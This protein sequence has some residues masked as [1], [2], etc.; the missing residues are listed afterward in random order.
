LRSQLVEEIRS[1]ARDRSPVELD[2]VAMNLLGD[3][4]DEVIKTF[5]GERSRRSNAVRSGF[6]VYESVG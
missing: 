6:P 4:V 1:Q 3:E 5:V 2:A